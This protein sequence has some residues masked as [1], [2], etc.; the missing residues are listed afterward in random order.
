MS[1]P[2]QLYYKSVA[3][4][5]ITNYN[6][7]VSDVNKYLESEINKYYSTYASTV[8]QRIQEWNIQHREV[9]EKIA[10]VENEIDGILKRQQ[11]IKTIITQI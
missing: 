3:N 9:K 1:V 5:C 2:V 7:Y 4:D 6:N 8:N 10:M 11:S